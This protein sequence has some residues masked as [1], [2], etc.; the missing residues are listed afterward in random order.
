MESLINIYNRLDITKWFGDFPQP[1][2][3][4]DFDVKTPGIEKRVVKMF[5]M[6][7]SLFAVSKTPV[8]VTFDP[9][10]SS[11]S[12]DSKII[13]IGLSPL[14]YDLPLKDR[15]Y[16]FFGEFI[17][18]SGHLMFTNPA[19]LKH[20][21]SIRTHPST[22]FE[23][24]FNTQTKRILANILEDRRIEHLMSV[25]YP[26]YNR[27]LKATRTAI[28]AGYLQ[29]DVKHYINSVYLALM[30]YISIIVLFPALKE[31]KTVQ[32]RELYLYLQSRV[33]LDKIDAICK[34]R[35]DDYEDIIKQVYD[36]AQF[37]ADAD[38]D[39][40]FM[41]TKDAMPGGTPANSSSLEAKSS[42]SDSKTASSIR[43]A[44][45]N[46][47]NTLSSIASGKITPE[48]SSIK[49]DMKD[50]ENKFHF[51]DGVGSMYEKYDL[52]YPS[53]RSK[54]SREAMAL[55]K[56]LSISFKTF[57]AASNRSV[58]SFEQEEGELDEDDLYEASFN[59][60]IFVDEQQAPD[61]S[62]ELCVLCDL[63]GSMSGPR[64]NKQADIATALGLAFAN[65]PRI[66]FSMYG[67]TADLGGNHKP[68]TLYVFADK[69]HRFD[70]EISQA[71]RAYSN[72]ADGYALK[73]VAATFK[74]N[75]RNKIIL[76]L[77]DGTPQANRYNGRAADD[78]L[79]SVVKSI[80]Q[81]GIQILSVAIGNFDQEDLYTNIIKYDGKDV[82]QKIA[83]W[84]TKKFRG[85]M[86]QMTF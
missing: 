3:F 19:I 37:F 79:R 49:G 4:I 64:I 62:L 33:P 7:V 51:E 83:Y 82:G 36:L 68:L 14:E 76:M 23:N 57:V 21:T 48:D 74:S 61:S 10:S 72:N 41:E 25:K 81:Q 6:L 42:K 69:T 20:A 67:H 22:I 52:T 29:N 85:Q 32:Y 84:I 5:R 60:N 70:P 45:M 80:E 35:Y 44:L 17:H 34:V 9:S 78:H 50:S 39:R 66:T 58:T 63:S 38:P 59:R 11:C 47:S 31:E 24:L 71:M 16:S 77:S 43:K 30:L 46:D 15:I 28:I 86:Q 18:E 13:T 8:T 1:L 27:Y 65:N 55:S 54:V 40:P 26:G 53:E 56:Q 75:S 2:S 73:R 12:V